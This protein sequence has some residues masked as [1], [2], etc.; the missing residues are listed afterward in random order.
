MQDRLNSLKQK[1]FYELLDIVGRVFV[2][3]RYAEDV[4]IGS[5]GFLPEE[6]EDGLVLVLNR[7]MDFSWRDGVLEC[8]LVFGATPQTC[9]IPERH[10]VAIHSPELQTQFVTV[11]EDTGAIAEAGETPPADAGSDRG[12]EP[13]V[14]KVDFTRKRH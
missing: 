10:I 14:V 5:R 13:K 9:L 11:P 12:S 6:R 8:R 3:V 2:V 4:Q 7:R 1:V